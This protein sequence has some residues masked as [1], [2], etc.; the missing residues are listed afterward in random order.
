MPCQKNVITH[1]LSKPETAIIS[2]EITKLLSKEVI[3]ESYSETEEY[4][5]Y[6][7]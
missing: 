3:V 1:V 4:I 5:K 6:R 2:E 7:Y